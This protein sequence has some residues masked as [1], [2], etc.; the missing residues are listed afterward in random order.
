M[1]R[2]ESGPK[3]SSIHTAAK[4][5]SC[6]ISS[7]I[8]SDVVE[9]KTNRSWPAVTAACSRLSVPVTLTSTKACAEARAMSGL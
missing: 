3:P 5:A 9:V 8:I 4:L 7:E 2:G 6:R 1:F